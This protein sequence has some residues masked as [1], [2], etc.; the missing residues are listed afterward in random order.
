MIKTGVEI[1][2]ANLNIPRLAMTDCITDCFCGD[3]IKM[4]ASCAISLFHITC[5]FEA[6]F[7]MKKVLCFCRQFLECFGQI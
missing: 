5:A 7:D 6:A 3:P 1:F 4:N 2:N